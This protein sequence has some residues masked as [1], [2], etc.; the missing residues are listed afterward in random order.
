MI[1]TIEGCQVENLDQSTYDTH[2]SA[3]EL[4]VHRGQ[5]FTCREV[6]EQFGDCEYPKKHCKHFPDKGHPKFI[7][8]EE[9]HRP[10]NAKEAFKVV[11]IDGEK[12]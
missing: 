7:F 10:H 3:G 8:S 5:L 2:L 4:Y 6:E 12:L 9:S 1:L 11:A